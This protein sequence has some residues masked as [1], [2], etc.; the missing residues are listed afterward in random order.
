MKK[1]QD[2]PDADVLNGKA[3]LFSSSFPDPGLRMLDAF[4]RKSR[5]KAVNAAKDGVELVVLVKL[6]DFVASF[7]KTEEN[8][9]ILAI[10]LLGIDATG[11]R[12]HARV[13]DEVPERSRNRQTFQSLLQKFLPC[14][15]RSSENLM[16]WPLGAILMIPWRK[17]SAPYFSIKSSG[18]GE[19]PGETWTSF[20]PP[21]HG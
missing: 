13:V 17:P 7:G 2:L 18:S 19:L 5:S 4:N 21:R 1:E 15:M 20:G 3:G 14:S 9:L 16:S 8:G 6:V 11:N 12:A 10:Y